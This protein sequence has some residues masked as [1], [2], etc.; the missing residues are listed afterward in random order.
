MINRFW[1]ITIIILFL[2]MVAG[3]LYLIYPPDKKIN[4]GL[5]LS[6]GIQIILSPEE[7]ISEDSIREAFLMIKDRVKRLKI[8]ESRVTM[9]ESKRILVQLPKIDN[10]E[11]I[12]S[13]IKNRGYLELKIVKGIDVG[14]KY[15]EKKE[16]EPSKAEEEESSGAEEE[17]KD[18][19][20]KTTDEGVK[21]SPEEIEQ[22][23]LMILEKF[24]EQLGEENI[25]YE[26]ISDLEFNL[27]LKGANLQNTYIAILQLT[28]G[29][30]S[31]S[32][33]IERIEIT[34]YDPIYGDT[35]AI[36]GH[37]KD[38]KPIPAQRGY[39]EMKNS[40]ILNLDEELQK[41]FKSL[42]EQNI[43]DDLS[44]VLD[45]AFRT[46]TDISE[47]TIPDE[48]A[49]LIYIP[50][51][52]TFEEAENISIMLQTGTLPI[53]FKVDNKVDVGPT[54]GEDIIYKSLIAIYVGFALVLISMLIYYRS[55]GLVS[56]IS[57]I[58][59]LI[60]LFSIVTLTKVVLTIYSFS[61]IFLAVGVY[62]FSNILIYEKVKEELKKGRSITTSI[63]FGFKNSLNDI[64]Y[65]NMSIFV[66]ALVVN[67]FG[68]K[69]LK[70]LSLPA[71]IGSIL[72]IITLFTFTRSSL[73]L[74][75]GFLQKYSLKPFLRKNVS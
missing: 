13:I 33:T 68:T 63:D 7:E 48:E 32:E 66:I 29:E 25:E 34:K 52:E 15:I 12:I 8:V 71:I 53:N 47:E 51:I 49:N 65:I 9:D 27:K 17:T 21:I 24:K 70:G 38:V 58:M 40:V 39:Q 73:L 3:A 43:G 5:D 6:G 46:I 28:M 14:L 64:F 10:L 30:I 50:N 11:S 75:S 37:L 19:D 74:S 62:V 16:E 44:I 2:I 35:V 56:V 54:L 1:H 69:Q 61:G 67:Y 55:L 18:K 26:K 42:L 59:F 45:G 20:K 60:L 22:T 57:L 4:T 72:T 31:E 23:T 36:S 41:R